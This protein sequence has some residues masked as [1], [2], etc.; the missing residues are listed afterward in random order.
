MNSIDGKN[1]CL[2]DKQVEYHEYIIESKKEVTVNDSQSDKTNEKL[3]NYFEV[4][5]MVNE[6][7]KKNKKTLK[8]FRELSGAIKAEI[9]VEFCVD[10]N[11][12][13]KEFAFTTDNDL[14][15]VKPIVT[16]SNC[17]KTFNIHTHPKVKGDLLTGKSIHSINDKNYYNSRLLDS[18]DNLTCGC[19]MGEAD[20]KISCLC[21]SK[22]L[23]NETTPDK[24]EVFEKKL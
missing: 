4:E 11:G 8:A 9:D 1:Y 20:K 23:T 21:N 15:F 24:I 7:M 14:Y 6:A 17:P 3:R 2:K 19:V 12:N 5:N 16:N 22:K 10:Q 13:G 18:K